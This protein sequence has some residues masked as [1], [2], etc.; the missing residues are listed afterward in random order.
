ML[1]KV[2]STSAQTPRPCDKYIT[3][4]FQNS[5]KKTWQSLDSHV[6]CVCRL[7]KDKTLNYL[8][9]AHMYEEYS[10]ESEA[11]GIPAWPYDEFV[12]WRKRIEALKLEIEDKGWKYTL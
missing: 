7:R 4:I 3:I 1:I 6:Y 2:Y 5:Q 12:A 11:N 10:I 8:S 9:Y